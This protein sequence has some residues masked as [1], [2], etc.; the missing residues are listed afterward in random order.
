MKRKEAGC[1]FAPPWGWRG[2]CRLRQVDRDGQRSQSAEA[3][4][5]AGS[6]GCSARIDDVVSSPQTRLMVALI[7]SS[8]SRINSL[9][10]F[11][12][13]CSSSIWAM[14]ARCVS[15]FGKGSW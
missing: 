2:G 3:A 4:I 10:A 14:I 7:L 6:S 9:F 15:M 8:K 13:R 1:F 5:G 11:T 12:S